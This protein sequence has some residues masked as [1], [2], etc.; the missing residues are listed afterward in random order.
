MSKSRRCS[1]SR[2]L[3]CHTKPFGYYSGKTSLLRASESSVPGGPDRDIARYYP[4][5]MLS[6]PNE[7][8]C[9]LRVT[10]HAYT[11][12]ARSR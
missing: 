2:Y 8:S 5:P 1:S 10:Q 3:Y 7:S 4:H 11:P 9:S 12:P 6:S